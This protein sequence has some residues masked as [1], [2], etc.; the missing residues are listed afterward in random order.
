MIVRG[1]FNMQAYRVKQQRV[2]QYKQRN[3]YEIYNDDTRLILL[4]SYQT[5]VGYR[6]GDE[7]FIT[8]NKYSSTTSKQ[9]TQYVNENNFTRYDISE[10]DLID[11][12]Y[13]N[14]LA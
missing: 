12:I 8:K 7:C 11:T 5:I 6:N 13:F 2:K 10:Q 9:Q 3:F 4:K 1:Y 14:N